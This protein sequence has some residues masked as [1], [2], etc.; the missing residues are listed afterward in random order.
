MKRVVT[1]QQFYLVQGET[2]RQGRN[3]RPYCGLCAMVAARF[4]D[5][6]R[7][8][9]VNDVLGLRL[10]LDHARGDA[11]YQGRHL[12]LNGLDELDRLFTCKLC[13]Q[14]WPLKAWL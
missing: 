13:F 2:K 7:T 8:G 12:V 6:T 3:P 14:K 9:Q 1:R 5:V 4:L 11:G 10:N